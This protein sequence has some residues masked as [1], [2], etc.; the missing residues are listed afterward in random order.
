MRFYV[1][2][3]LDDPTAAQTQIA[4]GLKLIAQS[5]RRANEVK[6]KANVTVVIGNPPYRERAEGMG[7]WVEKGSE[8]HGKNA[9]GVLEDW[10]DP[11]TARH[12][13]NLKN[14][15]VYFWRWATWKVWESTPENP[16]DGDAG[17]IC[18]I[19]TSGYVGGPGFSKMREYLRRYAT[20]GWVID[21]TPEGQTPD[22]PTRIFPGVRQPLA[23]GLFVRKAGAARDVPATIHYRA[24]HGRQ[25]EKFAELAKVSLDD[26]GWR[27]ART[28]WTA[29]L[30]PAA[31]TA[32]DDYPALNDVLP[33]TSPGVTGNRRWPYGPSPSVLQE[34]WRTLQAEQTLTD[35]PS[36]SRRRAIGHS[37]RRPRP[38]LDCVAHRSHRSGRT[39]VPD[40][41]QFA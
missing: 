34:R 28:G 19:S 18:F 22:V 7:G 21:L 15:Y 33:W 23:I 8:A 17:V 26:K 2:D 16:D 20:E 39:T 14:L 10:R 38:F 24:L 35:V 1:T 11:D 5:R 25:A 36:Y 27:Q 32:W 13:H 4:S 9:R 6:A 40:S 12:F 3:T 29:P 31:D 37:Q 41:R 30:T